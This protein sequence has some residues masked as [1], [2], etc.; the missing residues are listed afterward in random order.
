MPPSRILPLL[1]L[2]LFTLILGWQMGVR[3]E[4][5]ELLSLQKKLET[6]YAPS[7]ESGSITGDPE[8][9]VDLS[10]LWGVWRVLQA[11]YV[12]PDALH[13]RDMVYGAIQGLVAGVG[14]P[15]TAF[16]TPQESTEFQ[17]SLQGHLQGI[18]A[19]LALRNSTIVVVA[20][21]KGSPAER[22]GLLP[23]DIILE[24][25]GEEMIGKTLT[26]VVSR[27]RGEKGTVVTLTILRE[28]EAEPLTFTITRDD[29]T[30][31]S[32]EFE[33]RQTG[34]GAVGLLTINQF[35]GETVREVLG[36][37]R[38]IDP[39]KMKGL[40][41]DLRFNG[42]GYLEGAVDLSSIFLP[43]GRIVTVEGRGGAQEQHSA[44]GNP[45]LPDLPLVILINEG[46]ASASEIVAGAL[47]DHRRATI[48][49]MQSFGKG[50]VQEVID[51]P[52]GSSLRVTIAKWLT[53]NGR[54]LGK[55]GVTPDITVD[56]PRQTSEDAG[57]PQLQAAFEW[58]L[59][60]ERPP[61]KSGS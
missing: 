51:L 60:G 5:E 34:T 26:E 32:T 24:V 8:R 12:D 40:I 3:A 13:T 33:V 59:D 57:D 23:R 55:E 25:N 15:Y 58:L 21:L 44:S 1:A 49:G 22:A 9:E 27:I 41:I 46:T 31:P 10:L 39:A 6:L 11:R 19:E 48:V 20:P 2:P 56:R 16:M 36:F 14:D 54:D 37:V 50:T 29:I 35:G 47:Q 45:L 52:G 18:G 38:T 17:D 4:Q 28:E 43:G 61:E 30:I 7:V 53:P 42:G